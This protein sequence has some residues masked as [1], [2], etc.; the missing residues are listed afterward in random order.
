MN[1]ALKTLESLLQ[2]A[3]AGPRPFP[4]N[5]R[6]NGQAVLAHAAPGGRQVAYLARRV[7]PPPGRFAAVQTHTVAAGDRLDTLSARYAGDPEQWWRIADANGAMR[8]DELVE[9]PGR[10]L[11]ITLAEGIPA[12]SSDE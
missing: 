3:A 6:Y 10:R 11:R 7:V 12:G 4:P 8:P 9:T 5:S 2:N 1:D